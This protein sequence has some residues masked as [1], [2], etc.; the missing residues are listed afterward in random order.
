MSQGLTEE[1]FG[2]AHYRSPQG[3]LFSVWKNLNNPS[4]IGS[5]LAFL[6]VPEPDSHLLIEVTIEI[7]QDSI[8]VNIQDPTKQITKSFSEAKN[9]FKMVDRYA[10]RNSLTSFDPKKKKHEE[11]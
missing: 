11:I 6:T 3:L 7:S 9:A 2:Y 10:K 5:Y 1:K 8:Q 4:L